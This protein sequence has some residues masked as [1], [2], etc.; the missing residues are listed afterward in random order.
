MDYL[1]ASTVEYNPTSSILTVKQAFIGLDSRDFDSS[2]KF[3]TNGNIIRTAVASS[4]G[5]NINYVLV[6]SVQ[7]S[8]SRRQLLSLA[9]ISS[10]TYTLSLASISSSVIKAALTKATA[11]GTLAKNLILAASSLGTADNHY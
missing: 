4:I 11:D 10:V 1:S 8:N 9:L 2:T 3:T 7:D 5:L 6:V